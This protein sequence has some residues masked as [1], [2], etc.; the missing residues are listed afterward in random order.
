MCILHDNKFLFRCQK[1]NLSIFLTY[2]LHFEKIGFFICTITHKKSN[3]I[4]FFRQEYLLTKMKQKQ[5]KTD[6]L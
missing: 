6:N 4:S 2:F 1:K 3:G 5:K